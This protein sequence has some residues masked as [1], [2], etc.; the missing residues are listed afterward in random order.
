MQVVVSLVL[1][2]LSV[3]LHSTSLPGVGDEASGQLVT[4]CRLEECWLSK[5][6]AGVA[7]A[8][9]SATPGENADGSRHKV[10]R[11]LQGQCDV[12]ISTSMREYI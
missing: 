10:G 1:S 9:I 5:L 8:Q 6:G 11:L 3:P 12:L 7:K 2:L 4:G